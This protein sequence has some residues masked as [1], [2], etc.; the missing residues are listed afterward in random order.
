MNYERHRAQGTVKVGCSI[1]Q[2]VLMYYYRDL[3]VMFSIND[4][5]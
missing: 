3:D 2:S 4:E 1:S 5:L